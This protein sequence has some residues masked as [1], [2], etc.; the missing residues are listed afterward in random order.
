[1]ATNERSNLYGGGNI[2]RLCNNI[3]T[4]TPVYVK[5]NH[6][7]VPR[8]VGTLL[9][10]VKIPI[11]DPHC[12]NSAEMVSIGLAN[13]VAIP[14]DTK[15]KIHELNISNVPLAYSPSL[16]LTPASIAGIYNCANI[17]D[18]IF[19]PGTVAVVRPFQQIAINNLLKW[20]HSRDNSTT[21]GLDNHKGEIS[22]ERNSGKKRS[23]ELFK[24]EIRERRYRD[25]ALVLEILAVVNRRD[26]RNVKGNS[27]VGKNLVVEE[28]NFEVKEHKFSS[29]TS[30]VQSSETKNK[31]NW[32]N[33]KSNCMVGVEIEETIDL[34]WKGACLNFIKGVEL[35]IECCMG[36]FNKSNNYLAMPKSTNKGK[37][38]GA[39]GGG[40]TDGAEEPQPLLL[41]QRA[42]LL[43][44][45]TWPKRTHCY[46]PFPKTSILEPSTPL[47]T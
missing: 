24:K 45:W 38:G 18:F 17:R 8:T 11:R 33:K 12:Y 1:M 6:P 35:C 2:D 23:C 25:V 30:L 36:L 9:A 42:H 29:S 44:I 15:N 39:K 43:R 16:Q 41:S 34:I 27:V 14:K 13:Q 21:V 4:A 19:P 31:T 46:T 3:T 47:A 5:D 32:K 28:K 22:G 26:R 10:Q 40:A 7:D 20:F 37:G